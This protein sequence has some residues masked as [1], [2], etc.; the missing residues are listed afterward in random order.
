MCTRTEMVENPALYC[1]WW[2]QQPVG[3]ASHVCVPLFGCVRYILKKTYQYAS[4][5]RTAIGVDSSS[6]FNKERKKDKMKEKSTL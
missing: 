3:T 6:E 4:G 5:H 2:L 1:K